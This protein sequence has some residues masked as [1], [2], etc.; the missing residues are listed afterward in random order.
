MRHFEDFRFSG[1]SFEDRDSPTALLSAVARASIALADFQ[2]RL[3]ARICEFSVKLDREPPKDLHRLS[4][5]RVVDLLQEVMELASEQDRLNVGDNDQRNFVGELIELLRE[6]SKQYRRLVTP[7]LLALHLRNTV[8]LDLPGRIMDVADY[9]TYAVMMLDETF[10][11]V[12]PI[13]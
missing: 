11:V 13:N 6:A 12:D 7:D 4:P 3:S 2:K 1:D 5:D 9:V 8:P 10:L